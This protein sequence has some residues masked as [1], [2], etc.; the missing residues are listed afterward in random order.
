MRAA[1]CPVLH[2][3][4]QACPVTWSQPHDGVPHSMPPYLHAF[5]F[6]SQVPGS[7]FRGPSEGR[8]PDV[9]VRC[10]LAQLHGVDASPLCGWSTLGKVS[11]SSLSMSLLPG[12]AGCVNASVNMCEQPTHYIMGPER[13]CAPRGGGPAA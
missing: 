2:S 3:V 10:C 5:S 6:K 12:K 11:A 7:I 1:R 4:L 9:L 8:W 13:T